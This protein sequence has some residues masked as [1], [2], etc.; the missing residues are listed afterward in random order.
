MYELQKLID[1]GLDTGKLDKD[2]KDAIEVVKTLSDGF[3]TE[4]DTAKELD[5]A[6]AAAIKK[7]APEAIGAKKPAAKK[8]AEPKDADAEKAKNLVANL[9]KELISRNIQWQKQLEETKSNLPGFRMDK[10]YKIL[11]PGVMELYAKDPNKY[12]VED[13]TGGAWMFK[14]AKQA[15]DK[16]LKEVEEKPKK[17]PPKK[18][19]E[20]KEAAKKAKY[21]KGE[22]VIINKG[23]DKG[24]EGIIATVRES[25][26]G[27]SYGV[28][29]EGSPTKAGEKQPV[30]F[31]ED[32]LISVFGQVMSL[33]DCEEILK[34][35]KDKTTA[36]MKEEARTSKKISEGVKQAQKKQP[37]VTARNNCIAE[38][39]KVITKRGYK[40]EELKK[41]K[42][43][44]AKEEK[45]MRKLFQRYADNLDKI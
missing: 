16:Y 36:E 42:K 38:L 12:S 41:A 6:T 34:A 30:S 5:K 20:P 40:D 32:E 9:K 33:D 25:A 35:M 8:K 28:I 14:T 24:K 43:E 29:Y 7:I 1:Q 22:P 13:S 3:T 45:E 19:A 21:K 44:A 15:V 4:D 23:T 18:K 37:I 26:V 11:V 31:M 10:G 2:T 39:Y 27:V 17:A